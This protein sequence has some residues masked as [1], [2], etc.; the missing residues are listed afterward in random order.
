MERWRHRL[1]S[2]FQPAL[3]VFTSSRVYVICSQMSRAGDGERRGGPG[4]QADRREAAGAGGGGS[5]REA[6]G[7]ARRPGDPPRSRRPCSLRQKYPMRR[8]QNNL[9]CRL[10]SDDR[11]HITPRP[12]RPGSRSTAVVFPEGLAVARFL[13]VSCLPAHRGPEADPRGPCFPVAWFL[14]AFRI[15]FVRPDGFPRFS[16]PALRGKDV[17]PNLWGPVSVN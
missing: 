10:V 1:R 5:D 7:A 14:L 17:L 13:S 2:T 8:E 3:A 9:H 15:L 12:S 16:P 4:T 6:R 11:G